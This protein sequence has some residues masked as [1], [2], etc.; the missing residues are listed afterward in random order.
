MKIELK[1]FKYHLQRI[2]E[3]KNRCFYRAIVTSLFLLL[4]QLSVFL[5]ERSRLTEK[6]GT[7][8]SNNAMVLE[9]LR[10]MF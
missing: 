2:V 10:E 9:R 6:F 5:R 7:T 1:P 3:Q 4:P 8:K